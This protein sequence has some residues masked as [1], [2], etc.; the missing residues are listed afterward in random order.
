VLSVSLYQRPLPA[1]EVPI[2]LEGTVGP[3]GF[4]FEAIPEFPFLL[5]VHSWIVPALR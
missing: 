1:R 5:Y 3:L 2:G 4:V